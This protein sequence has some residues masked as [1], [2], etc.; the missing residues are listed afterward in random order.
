MDSEILYR[1]LHDNGLISFCKNNLAPNAVYVLGVFVDTDGI[2]KVDTK[3]YPYLV[4]LYLELG[5]QTCGKFNGK[6]DFN[7]GDMVSPEAETGILM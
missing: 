3:Q 4:Q 1:D 6:L 7:L 5:A 2:V